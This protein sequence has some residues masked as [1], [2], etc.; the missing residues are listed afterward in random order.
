M[1]YLYDRE[2]YIGA[3]MECASAERDVHINSLHS[4][5]PSAHFKYPQR[6]DQIWVPEKHILA[7]IEP[8][9]E[10]HRQYHKSEEVQTQLTAQIKSETFR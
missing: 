5:A 7:V 10:N 1:A 8:A 9:T 6:T 4:K 2:W 3:V